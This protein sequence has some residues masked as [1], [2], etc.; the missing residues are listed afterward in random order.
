[1]GGID[2]E[3]HA[4]A[5]RA[6]PVRAEEFREL[7]EAVVFAG[8]STAVAD[9]ESF[10]RGRASVAVA[11]PARRGEPSAACPRS[12]AAYRRHAEV[13]VAARQPAHRRIDG[14]A[15]PAEAFI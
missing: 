9:V 12:T 4:R 3:R 13:L 10:G 5:L 2:C 14:R 8:R 6:D 7:A 15:R 11:V 1:M